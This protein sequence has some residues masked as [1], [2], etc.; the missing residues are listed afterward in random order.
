MLDKVYVQNDNFQCGN[1]GIGG[2]YWAH[3]DYNPKGDGR[4]A[5]LVA[6]IQSPWAGVYFRITDYNGWTTIKTMFNGDRIQFYL[7]LG[8][9]TIWPYIGVSV[10]PDKGDGIFWY[11]LVKSK[12]QDNHLTHKACPVV[13]GGKWIC[14]KWIGYDAQ[15]KH[16]NHKCALTEEARFYPHIR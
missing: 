16:D 13:L 4:A 6:I 5:T 7:F 8:G 1:Y 14:N 2:S 12:F 9:A 15:W 3:M 10:F 11:N